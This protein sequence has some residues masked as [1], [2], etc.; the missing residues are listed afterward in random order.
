MKY[1]EFIFRLVTLVV[2]TTA[3]VLIVNSGVAL[4]YLVG[5]VAIIAIVTV[6]TLLE[7]KIFSNLKKGIK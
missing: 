3:F 5:V 4:P 1:F 7:H 6:G 2:S